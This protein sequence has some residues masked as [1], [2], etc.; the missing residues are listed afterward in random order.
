MINNVEKMFIHNVSINYNFIKF[1]KSMLHKKIYCMKMMHKIEEMSVYSVN[2]NQSFTEFAKNM[3]HKKIYCI[4]VMHEVKEI[5]VHSNNE[6]S[7][8]A[9]SIMLKVIILAV[10]ITNLNEI[11]F[12]RDKISQI[13]S[14]TL[15]K[16]NNKM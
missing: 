13:K 6:T 9:K 12:L 15:I 10:C 1:I 11:H 4:K 7:V 14:T 5:F 16:A 8:N 2:M 3:L